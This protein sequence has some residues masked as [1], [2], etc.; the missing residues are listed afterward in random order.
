[1][2]ANF[3]PLPPFCELASYLYHNIHTTSLLFV[4]FFVT[5]LPLMRTTIFWASVI[6]VSCM[7]CFEIYI[8]E[9]GKGGDVNFKTSSPKPHETTEAQNKGVHTL[10]MP[11]NPISLLS[12]LLLH[13]PRRR[14]RRPHRVWKFAQLSSRISHCEGRNEGVI[15]AHKGRPQQSGHQA[16]K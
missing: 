1:M 14:R 3:T 6:G 10:W 9:G 2:Y 12:P 5:P 7:F 15:S 16:N 13:G 8:P 11:P 4:C